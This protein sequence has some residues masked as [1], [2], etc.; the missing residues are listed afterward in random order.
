M[1]QLERLKFLIQLLLSEYKN[2]LLQKLPNTEAELFQVYRSLVNV[3]PPKKAPDGFLEV[4][5]AYLQE[6]LL[7]RG[8]VSL[9]DMENFGNGLYLW[10]GDI[11]R[12]A[13][14]AIVNAANSQ[15]LGC[16]S[17]CHICIDNCIHTFAG[18]EL[19]NTCFR[20]IQKM[21]HEEET[22]DAQITPGY[23]LPS[24]FVL[25]TTGPIV[26]GI[27][28]P[29]QKAQL[30]TCYRN[31]LRVAEENGCKSIAFCCISTGAFGFPKDEAC[32]IAIRTVK[33]NKALDTKVIFNVFGEDDYLRY[34]QELS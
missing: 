13:C 11:T 23:N 12:I 16:F 1:T 33:E 15:M 18:I 32:K 7:K 21:G 30:A 17:P 25:H 31:C 3:R 10:R 9:V 22:G 14:D 26:S 19:R 28:L 8:T 29:S 6:N 5:D 20:V 4:Q 27:L 34:K 2:P 24:Q